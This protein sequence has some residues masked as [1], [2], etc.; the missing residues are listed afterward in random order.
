VQPIFSNALQCS[1]SP[2]FV[3]IADLLKKCEQ[4]V[5]GIDTSSTVLV[6]VGIKVF[7]H[8]GNQSVESQTLSTECRTGSK[9]TSIPDI[10]EVNIGCYSYLIPDIFQVIIGC[11]S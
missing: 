1:P 5:S 11:F 4:S 6:L 2:I 9:V 7:T 3:C 10:F 8:R